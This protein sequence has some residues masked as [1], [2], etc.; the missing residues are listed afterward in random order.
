MGRGRRG[1]RLSRR[2]ADKRKRA[3]TP[4]SEDCGD[5]KYLEKVS[6]G[7]ER[8]P[9]PA[10]PPALSDDSDDS[11][12]LSIAVRAYWHAIERA[13]LGGS[14]ESCNTLGVYRM[15]DHECGL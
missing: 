15:L 1:R 4:P 13:G 5:S 6:S 10:S 14:D 11:K 7:S 8:S 3:P 2:A 12:G 9:A